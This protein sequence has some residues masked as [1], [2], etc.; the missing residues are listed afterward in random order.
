[1]QVVDGSSSR[2]YG[3][4]TLTGVGAFSMN[5]Y[6]DKEYMGLM[7]RLCKYLT[8][9][10]FFLLPR[11]VTSMFVELSI[12]ILL[13][14][15]REVEGQNLV[16][17]EKLNRLLSSNYD[18]GIVVLPEYTVKWFW[19]DSYL[20]R[21]IELRN[22]KTTIKEVLVTDDLLKNNFDTIAN[23]LLDNLPLLIKMKLNLS[24]SRSKLNMKHKLTRLLYNE[25][26]QV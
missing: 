17:T 18:D 19:S 22:G 26:V 5:T 15:L 13:L 10:L 2:C 20:N 25:M 1:M 14:N 6:N 3:S 23:K 8:L 7:D 16:E 9:A 4:L 24:D 21:E 11:R 12:S